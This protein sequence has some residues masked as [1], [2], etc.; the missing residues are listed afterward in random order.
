MSGFCHRR[1]IT[2]SSVLSSFRHG[3][4]H[5]ALSGLKEKTFEIMAARIC[6]KAPGLEQSQ[7]V[8]PIA[9]QET[10]FLVE[11]S[12][13]WFLV[14]TF[15]LDFGIQTDPGIQLI[16]NNSVG[17]GRMSHRR[18]SSFNRRFDQGF[19]DFEENVLVGT[20]STAFKLISSL[21]Y[22]DT[23]SP[24]FGITNC[25]VGLN[26]L[27]FSWAT[28]VGLNLPKFQWASM[29]HIQLT[30]PK[31]RRPKEKDTTWNWFRVLKLASCCAVFPTWNTL[32]ATFWPFSN[33]VEFLLFEFM[34][35]QARTWNLEQLL[36]C[37]LVH[38][39]FMS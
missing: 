26:T 21:F 28:T 20:Q 32:W 35:V 39:I 14:S 16:K 17:S 7:T 12:A 18:T 8:I 36:S 38:N 11:M 37:L 23:L 5:N 3:T 25:R 34:V 24:G 2:R 9:S 15:D 19:V 30:E 27:E 1:R 33:W 6:W 10:S 22:L 29:T 31:V 4:N 13:S